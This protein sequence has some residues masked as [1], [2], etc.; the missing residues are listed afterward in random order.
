[1]VR[2]VNVVDNTPPTIT[3]LGDNPLTFE[4]AA[5]Y[6]DPGANVSDDCDANPQLVIDDS[7]VDTTTVGTYTVNFTATDASGNQA[8]A[9]RTVNVVDTT[10]PAITLNGDNP[11]TL[12]C[13]IDSYDEPGATASDACDGDVSG[14]IAIDASAVD[15]STPGSYSVTYNVSDSAGNAATEVTRTVNVA[16]TTPPVITLLGQ[17]PVTLECNIDTYTEAGATAT[18]ACDGDVSSSIVIDASAVDA[19]TPGSYSVTYNV[20]DSAGNAAT[21]AVRTV[22]VVD[23]TPPTITVA[24][25]LELWPPNHQ[26]VTVATTQSVV[27]VVDACAG[28]IPVGN[29]V[30]TSVSSDEPEDAN[31]GGDGN[32]KDDIVIA[33]D[34]QSVQV[35]LERQGSSNGR[36]YTIDLAVDDGNGNIATAQHQVTVPK[37]QNGNSAVDDGPIYTVY[38]SCSGIAAAPIAGISRL[39]LDGSVIVDSISE[40]FTRLIA[41]GGLRSVIIRNLRTN[42]IMKIPAAD[43]TYRL[44][45][46]LSQQSAI[47]VGDRLQVTAETVSPR[48]GIETAQHVVKASEIHAGWVLLPNLRV[49]ELPETTQLL[50]NYPNPFNPETWIPYR[51]AKA[52]NVTLTIYDMSGTMIRTL[53]IGHQSAA[54]Y[55]SKDKAIYWDGRNNF[56]ERV[57]SGVYFYHLQAGDY[58]ATRKMVILK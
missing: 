43:Q 6:T 15:T 5:S 38:S 30:I 52:A 13:N 51:L 2:T 21:E 33:T 32:T 37:S 11:L 29:V 36:V 25:S 40:H 39:T 18:D 14:S 9:T 16:D 24:A 55:E 26:Y 23:T 3:L 19:S 46:N 12:E 42:A 49:F 10:P 45:L 53:D 54:V 8:T 31:G 27:S 34:C 7:N 44:T 48:V 50:N 22:N 56:G 57:S 20:A 4:C 35:R 28:T 17:N 58:S 41:D 1:V 47:R